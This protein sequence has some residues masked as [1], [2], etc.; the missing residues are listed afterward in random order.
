M[1]E[2]YQELL[3]LGFLNLIQTLGMTTR[4]VYER[5]GILFFYHF[6]FS[7]I[8]YFVK[9]FSKELLHLGF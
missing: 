6:S 2:N 7:P 3:H 1:S 8:K 4:M 9:H 5:I